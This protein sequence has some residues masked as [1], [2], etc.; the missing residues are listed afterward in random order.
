MS[1]HSASSKMKYPISVNHKAIF[2][3]A[4][5]H[6][7]HR[8][9][10]VPDDVDIIVFAGDACVA[11]DETQLADFFAW[12]ASLPV[13]HKLFV[14]GNHD[15]PFDL[16]PD[17]AMQML[18]NGITCIDSGAVMLGG[19]RFYI[20]P[21]RPFLHE[22]TAPASIPAGIDILV[23]HGAP[24]GILDNGQGCIILRKLVDKAQPKVHIFGH[25]HTLGGKMATVGKTKFYN[26]A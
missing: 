12:Y 13:L 9:V 25:A 21:V 26:V 2:A 11:G 6:G 1:E 23:T 8:K 10:T 16:S 4:D 14:P 22:F 15:L 5:T 17:T 24:S 18:P 7:N 3:F 19:I 20:L